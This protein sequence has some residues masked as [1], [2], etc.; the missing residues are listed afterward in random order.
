MRIAIVNDSP[1]AREALRRIIQNSNRHSIAWVAEDGE[2]ACVM[3]TRPTADLILMD[4]VMPGKNGV[5][6]TKEIMQNSSLPILLVTSTLVGNAKLV[7]EALAAGAIDAVQ[8]PSQ[9]AL[10][11]CRLGSILLNKIDSIEQM[12]HGSMIPDD[13]SRNLKR[14]NFAQSL[15]CIGASTGGPGVLQSILKSIDPDPD[16]AVVIT[17]HLDSLF[18]PGLVEWLGQD[19]P[20]PVRAAV[21]GERPKHGVVY[22]AMTSDHLVISRHGSFQYCAEPVNLPYRPSVDEFFN[23]VA[24]HWTGAATGVLLTG[25]GRDG[26][27]GLLALR[28]AGHNTIAQDQASSAVY[29]MPKAAVAIQAAAQV[30]SREEICSAFSTKAKKSHASMESN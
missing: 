28:E 5:E 8:T 9:S 12:L 23:S 26:A 15:V 16:F 20:L 7:Y 10:G 25:M 29:G 30:L 17:Q 18:L 6:T 22:L 11:S 4:L 24:R 13:S 3:A 21:A 14:S 2:Q 1:I 27:K 19:S